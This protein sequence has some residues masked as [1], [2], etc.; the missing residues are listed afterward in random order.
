LIL[1]ACAC[2]INYEPG[3]FTDYFYMAKTQGFSGKIGCFHT[4]G[5]AYRETKRKI[6][7]RN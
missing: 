5:L 2:D 4:S 7:S 6:Y 3:F 1:T